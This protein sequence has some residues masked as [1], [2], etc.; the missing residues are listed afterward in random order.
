MVRFSKPSSA[1]PP[2]CPALVPGLAVNSVPHNQG[3]WG[4][5]F[6][7]LSHRALEWMLCRTNFSTQPQCLHVC[8][9]VGKFP[10]P[11]WSMCSPPEGA[12]H[13]WSQYR[14]CLPL[15]CPLQHH[16]ARCTFSS[17]SRNTS[18][19]H[20]SLCNSK[21]MPGEEQRQHHSGAPPALAPVPAAADQTSIPWDLSRGS[22]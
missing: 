1:M 2:L 13:G 12:H 5:L 6:F 20:E 9:F 11:P 8:I 15:L 14:D 16:S 3:Q 17:P 4:F 21:V 22:M 10:P 19:F 18:L 7:K